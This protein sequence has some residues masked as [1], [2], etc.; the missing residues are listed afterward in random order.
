M[1]GIH[2]LCVGEWKMHCIP[3]ILIYDTKDIYWLY[4]K[5]N[6]YFSALLGPAKL[7]PEKF[8]YIS[9]SI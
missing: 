6:I 8:V 5:S 9:V 3:T 2:A 1:V 4:I 7:M